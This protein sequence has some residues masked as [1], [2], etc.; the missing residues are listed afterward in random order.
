MKEWLNELM[1]ENTRYELHKECI[2][3]QT[4][5]VLSFFLSNVNKTSSI[6]DKY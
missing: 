5:R 4:N 1:N 2:G 6:N 3:F